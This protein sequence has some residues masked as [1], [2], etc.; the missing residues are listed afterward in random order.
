ML[1]VRGAQMMKLIIAGHGFFARGIKSSLD[2][3][4]GDTGNVIEVNGFTD[5]CPSPA[6][7]INELVNENDE[8]IVLTDVRFGSINQYFM[9][10]LEN[11]DFLLVSGANLP[12]AME[13]H[14]RTL[15]ELALEIGRAHV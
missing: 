8:F 4:S 13:I 12:L 14:Q 7:Y 5:E 2:I 15:N 11:K 6:G 3:I 9:K 1:K 10:E